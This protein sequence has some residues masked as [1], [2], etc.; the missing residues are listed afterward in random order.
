MAARGDI[1][2]SE[3]SSPE[4]GSTGAGRKH[5][6]STFDAEPG[7]DLEDSYHA[8]HGTTQADKKDMS[9]M[10]KTQELRVRLEASPLGCLTDDA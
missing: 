2:G 8:R 6:T 1:H 9:R 7:D 5:I 10:G 3:S 4:G